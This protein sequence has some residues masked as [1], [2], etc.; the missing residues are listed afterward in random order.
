MGKAVTIQE[1]FVGV[2]DD[3]SESGSSGKY[4]DGSCGDIFANATDRN[5]TQAVDE[6][7]RVRFCITETAGGTENQAFIL[8][9]NH[10]SAGW[11]SIGS[12]GPIKAAASAED[13]W[14]ITDT[15]STTDRLSGTGSFTAGEYSEDGNTAAVSLS[16]QYTNLEFC[17]TIDRGQPFL[18]V[19]PLNQLSPSAKQLKSAI[20]LQLMRL[21]RIRKLDRLLL[22]RRL[23][24]RRQVALPPMRPSLL[25]K[26]DL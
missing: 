14:S 17:L 9:Y 26:L 6:V 15:D 16:N 10:N 8:R 24:Q 22:M 19:T 7:F 21:L 13:G 23:R 20:R 25:R 3:G 4:A 11:V 5:W 2:C 1:L 18:I 12:T